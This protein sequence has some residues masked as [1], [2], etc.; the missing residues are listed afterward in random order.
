MPV[1]MPCPPAGLWMCAASPSRKSAA[2]TEV[3]RHAVVDAISRKPVHLFDFDLQIVDNTAADVLKPET[4]S[5][6]RSFVTYGA[7]QPCTSVSSQRKYGEE[8]SLFEINMEFTVHRGARGLDIR[9]IEKVT[10]GAAWKARAHPLAHHRVYAVASSDEGCLASLFLGARSAQTCD[11]V[12]I[13]ITVAEKLGLPFNR[14]ATFL[15]F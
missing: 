12:S 7:D 14:N 2:F 9:N 13:F 6:F 5:V 10:V 3:F 11:D 15:Q 1:F 8:I 4:I